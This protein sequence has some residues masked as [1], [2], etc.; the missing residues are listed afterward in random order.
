MSA[1]AA[2]IE[3]LDLREADAAD[4]VL[5]DAFA[6]YPVMRYTLGA[7]AG[8]AAALRRL[9]GL[10]TAGRWMR[11]HPVLGAR[12]ASGRLVGVVTMTPPGEFATPHALT[13]LTESTW[14][15]LGEAA[16]RRYEAIKSAWNATALP[17][18]RWHINM[19]GVLGSHRAQGYGELLLQAAR[20]F[21]AAGPQPH[22]IDL[23][24]EEETNLAF[25]RRRGFAVA[26]HARVDE[27]LET[28][29]LVSET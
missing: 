28:W 22:G 17:G 26:A 7:A 23:T 14:S 20:E 25:Y 9:I 1:P 12:E 27:R 6:A 10:F 16:R 2:R 29:T 18:A 4:A 15:A 3:M 5:C 8:D 13:A 21:A 24:T 11:G 19:L